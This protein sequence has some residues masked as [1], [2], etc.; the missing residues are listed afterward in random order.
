LKAKEIR[1][2]NIEEVAKQIETTHQELFDL[3]SRLATKQLVNHR[4]IRAV[5]KKLARLNTI[6]RERELEQ[7]KQS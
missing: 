6:M 1:T 2:L 5:K 4:E 7:V 3:R